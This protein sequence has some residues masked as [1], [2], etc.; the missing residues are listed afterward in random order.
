MKRQIDAASRRQWRAVLASGPIALAAAFTA[1]SWPAQA[2]ETDWT[3]AIS[4]DWR[5]AGNW[6]AG[7]PDQFTEAHLN[8]IAPNATVLS[9]LG[10]Q[11]VGLLFVGF[12]NTGTFTLQ[13]GATLFSDSTVIGN[14]ASAVGLATVTGAQLTHSITPP[15]GQ[16]FVGN[17]GNGTLVIN[18]GA[19]VDSRS[20][21]IG[22]QAGSQGS[23]TVTGANWRTED[24]YVGFDGSAAL[25][26]AAGGHVTTANCVVCVEVGLNPSSHGTVTVTGSG[27]TWSIPRSISVGGSHGGT[28]E[29]TIA[30]G[31]SVSAG[32]VMLAQASGSTGTL[33]IG[34]PAGAPAVA[35]GTLDSPSVVFGAGTGAINF[36][37]TATNYLF[38]PAISGSGAVNMIAGTTTLTG[39]NTYTGGTTINGGTLAVAAD[40]N[41]GGAA[42]RLAFGGGTL[43]FSSGFTTNRVVTLN[44]GG[45]T[46][47]T[48]GNN[49][50]LLGAISGSGSLTKIGA[51]VLTLSGAN[52][53]TGG[54]TL[55]AGT[56]SLATSQALGAGALTTTGSVLDY[57][58]GVT[59]ANPIV[60]NSNTTQLQVL[61]GSAIQSGV[62]SEL[63]GP[64]PLEKI[65]AGTLVLTGNNTY[66]GPTRITAGTL[67]LGNGGT[68]GSILGNVVNAPTRSL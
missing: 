37:H 42:G 67:Q 68:S 11:T 17:F 25:T 61:T 65:G 10:A 29:L 53:Y 64:R 39:A 31:G 20:T 19:S 32:G 54:T 33:N 4:T 45:G 24:F 48:N 13:N 8:T 50:T 34:A 63:N 43:Q 66:S 62:I 58:N 12:N 47:D 59:I 16:L 36:N 57:A 23:V 52:T 49:A 18:N 30:D 3:G 1:I 5:N 40:A 2:A 22:V 38:A 9:G 7:V 26:I 15:S 6:T 28:G 60:V 46:F 44:A 56:L 27:A 41:L 51:G 14:A 21:I 55:A 35:P